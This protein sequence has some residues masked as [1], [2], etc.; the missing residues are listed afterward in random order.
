MQV[1]F[2][3]GG[4]ERCLMQIILSFS[5]G[6]RVPTWQNHWQVTE[7]FLTPQLRQYFWIKLEL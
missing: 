5:G 4:K 6:Q 1:V 7:K 3:L 2:P